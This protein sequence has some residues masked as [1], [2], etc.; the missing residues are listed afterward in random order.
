VGDNGFDDEYDER[1]GTGGGYVNDDGDDRVR[2]SVFSIF[3]KLMHSCCRREA[4][5]GDDE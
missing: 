1:N 4:T 2:H 3:L 5:V